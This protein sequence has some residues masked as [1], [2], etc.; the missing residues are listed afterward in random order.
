MNTTHTRSLSLLGLSTLLAL[1]AGCASTSKPGAPATPAA[2]IAPATVERQEKL[3]KDGYVALDAKSYDEALR[4]FTQ[5]FELSPSAVGQ[6]MIGDCYWVQRKHGNTDPRLLEK[7]D[8]HY[9]KALALD[10]AHHGSNHA[11]GRDLV[12]LKR[13]AEALP[14]LDA[15]DRTSAG[16]SLASQNLLF[17]VNANIALGKTAEA[18]ADFA[19]LLKDHAG[20]WNTYDAGIKLGTHKGDQAMIA[21]YKGAK[22]RSL[23]QKKLSKAGY[24]ALDAKAFDEAIS[25]LTKAYELNPSAEGQAQIGDCYYPQWELNKS[26]TRLLE[27][28]NVHYLKALELDPKHVGANHAV[29]TNLMRLKRP[30][31]AVRYFSDADRYSA[32]SILTAQNLQ[33][34]MDAY[35]ALGK[36]TEAEADFARLLKDHGDDLS[37]YL[38]GKKLGTHKGDQAMV[39]HY[40]DLLKRWKEERKTAEVE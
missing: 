14:Y 27:K 18:E 31:E 29:G 37:T 11:L 12:L 9:L 19:R 30:A 5:A 33:W 21:N 13:P 34:R 3:I 26:D 25:L 6:A 15:A 39:A 28:A 17:R 16:S 2:Q 35:I 1:S 24:A 22:E 38:A 32:G 23:R 7:A 10:P 40:Q 20:D 4:L 36:T 8:I